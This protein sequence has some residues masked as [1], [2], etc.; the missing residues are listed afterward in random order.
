MIVTKQIPVGT[1]TEEAPAVPDENNVV[2]AAPAGPEP[3]ANATPTSAVATAPSPAP[4]TRQPTGTPSAKIWPPGSEQAKSSIFFSK[5]PGSP[6]PA[7]YPPC[8]GRRRATEL[9]AAFADI[10]PALLTRA[11]L[12]DAGSGSAGRD[13]LADAIECAED[14][15]GG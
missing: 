6:Q 10:D 12:G 13:L 1:V 4:A 5:R 2:D 15:C 8:R 14:Q 3:M 9:W 7:P 11:L